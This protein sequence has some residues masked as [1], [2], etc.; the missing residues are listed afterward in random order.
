MPKNVLF[1]TYSRFNLQPHTRLTGKC[2]LYRPNSEP[3]NS[4][5]HTRLT[6]TEEP[7]LAV[8]EFFQFT[9]SYEA[10][11]GN[12]TTMVRLWVF[13]FTASYEADLVL[14]RKMEKR[15]SFNSQ[16]HTRLTQINRFGGL[17]VRLSIHSLIRGWPLFAFP[18]LRKLIL[19]IH[20]LIRG[21]PR[22][23][24]FLI[25]V[26]SFNSQPHTRLTKFNIPSK[27]HLHLSI[28]SLIRGWPGF[29]IGEV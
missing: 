25:T 14:V 28:H 20:S 4:Q 13:Q 15:G 19:S 5:P 1:S 27:S 11:P 8:Q 2:H 9:A 16:P 24:C 29:I 21:W 3:F 22:L 7:M 17:V 12:I 6:T 10:D 23:E 18:I 26:T